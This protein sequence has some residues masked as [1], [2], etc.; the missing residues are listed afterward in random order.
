M[1]MKHARRIPKK[2]PFE[3][4]T[5][6]DLIVSQFISDLEQCYRNFFLP[7]STTKHV[8]V[9]VPYSTPLKRLCV[10]YDCSTPLIFILYLYGIIKTGPIDRLR[11][12]KMAGKNKQLCHKSRQVCDHLPEGQ[13]S[14]LLANS[15][16]QK[17]KQCQSKLIKKL[18]LCREEVTA[19]TS[20]ERQGVKLCKK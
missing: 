9:C 10:P 11:Q 17:C 16:P 15:H 8:R 19:A 4:S 12:R 2:S 5:L 7:Y 18:A 3:C 1:E 14:P 20:L 13:A 6:S